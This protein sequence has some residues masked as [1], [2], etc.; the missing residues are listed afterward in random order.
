[1]PF[2]PGLAFNWGIP[3]AWVSVTGH[4][5]PLPIWVLFFGGVWYVPR[6]PPITSFEYLH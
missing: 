1:M 6:L 5:P 4:I 2:S 3:L